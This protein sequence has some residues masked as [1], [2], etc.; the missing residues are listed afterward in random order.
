M[1]ST[2]RSAIMLFTVI[3]GLAL[4]DHSRAA[5]APLKKNFQRNLP[6]V[7]ISVDSVRRISTAD[8]PAEV[9]L[10]IILK[11]RVKDNMSDYIKECT[12]Q[13]NPYLNFNGNCKEA[14]ETY[15]RIF[16]GKI[17]ALLPH[18]GT[19]AEQHTPPEWQDKILHA[20]LNVNGQVL[21]ASD[22]PPKSYKPIEGFAVSLGIT[23]IREAERI[24]RELSEGGRITMPLQ[25]TFWAVGF[26]MLTDRFGIP[27][28]INCDK[29]TA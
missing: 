14:F 27:W 26:G 21:M 18:A 8:D 1:R 25:P 19:P 10:R 20:R 23:D 12:M 9:T 11:D 6:A 29:P 4:L 28:M 24:F 16:K 15:E 22:I 13:I 17:E 5:F 7:S 2:T 3:Y